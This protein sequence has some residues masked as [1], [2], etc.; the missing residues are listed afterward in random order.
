MH[1]AKLNH[2]VAVACSGRL[3]TSWLEYSIT[4][5]MFETDSASFSVPWSQQAWDLL[6]TD[7]SV[8]MAVDGVTRLEG[9]IDDRDG[10]DAARTIRIAC[11]SKEGRLVDESAP[12]VNYSGLTLS[13]LVGKLVDPWFPSVALSNLRNRNVARGKGHKAPGSGKVFVDSSSGTRIEPGQPR[14]SVI[15][16]L[17]EQV[18]AAG[19]ASADGKEYVIGQPDYEQEI[20]FA[21]RSGLAPGGGDGTALRVAVKDSTAERYSSITVLGSGAG[22]DGNYGTGPSKRAATVKDN[23][24]TT[25]GEGLAFSAPKRLVIADRDDVRSSKEALRRATRES[26]RRQLRAHM[27]TV[28]AP[29][30]GQVAAGRVPT[31][32]TPDTLCR[33]VDP[34]IPGGAGIYLIAEVAFTASRSGGERTTMQLIPKG[35]ELVP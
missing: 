14:Q 12:Q 4:N 34:R 1:S 2:H 25:H 31:L 28:E 6:S 9:F 5:S 23:P 27:V 18:G 19:W 20:Q 26:A 11:R 7:R 10:D 32:F 29:G 22:D 35:M 33:L 8:L 3:V 30:H 16:E 13:A 17:L 15:N 21:F 24:A